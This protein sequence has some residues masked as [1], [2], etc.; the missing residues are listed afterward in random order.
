MSEVNLKG[1]GVAL[2][3]PFTRDGLVDFEA[4][5]RLVNFQI[6]NGTSYIVALGTTAETP[7]LTGIEKADVAQSP[8]YGQC[9][10]QAGQCPEI[11][12]SQ[13]LPVR[14]NDAGCD[15]RRAQGDDKHQIDAYE[16]F[17]P[18]DKNHISTSFPEISTVSI[19]ENNRFVNRNRRD[20]HADSVHSFACRASDPAHFR[21]SPKI[22]C[23]LD[24][25][26]DHRST[27][28]RAGV[29]AGCLL[30]RSARLR[31]HAGADVFRRSDFRL[32]HRGHL[33]GDAGDI[34]GAG[35][36]F[37]KKVKTKNLVKEWL[38]EYKKI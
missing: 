14:Q 26:M 25:H 10:E 4:L 21:H 30:R 7:T 20:R 12:I 8:H 1:L 35:D 28:R 15:D 6:E 31:H 19:A 24:G 9:A 29:G 3:T 2:I 17:Q 38:N 33:L 5:S 23:L 11:K 22:H 37:E 18:S 34:G 32:R 36:Y 27:F 16:L 13:I